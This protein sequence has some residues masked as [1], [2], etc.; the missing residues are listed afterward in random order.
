MCYF[1]LFL[2]LFAN[3]FICFTHHLGL[4]VHTFSYCYP[5]RPIIRLQVGLDA[6]KAIGQARKAEE[7]LGKAVLTGE[8]LKASLE[9]EALRGNQVWGGLESGV[10]REIRHEAAE[11]VLW[12]T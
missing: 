5:M 7:A 1:V 12:D 4:V 10:E 3:G 9:A 8:A 2:R 6:M 11:L